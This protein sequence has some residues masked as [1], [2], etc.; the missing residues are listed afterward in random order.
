MNTD[1]QTAEVEVVTD[2]KLVKYAKARTAIDAA[3]AERKAAA[4]PDNAKAQAFAG[5][6]RAMTM[7]KFNTKNF[8][9][10]PARVEALAKW[11]ESQIS[12]KDLL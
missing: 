3:A 9:E 5:I 2:D 7:P 1:T 12:T 10:L 8:V 11:I 4:A 6:L